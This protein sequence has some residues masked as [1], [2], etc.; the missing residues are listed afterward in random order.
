ME[1]EKLWIDQ[2][3]FKI[4]GDD[5]F[6]REWIWSEKVD[7]NILH[8]IV[9]YTWLYKQPLYKWLYGDKLLIFEL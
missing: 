8:D 9:D 2:G 4:E 5:E 3:S 7:E 6:D 1:S